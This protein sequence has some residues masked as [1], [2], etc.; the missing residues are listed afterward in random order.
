MNLSPP[1]LPPLAL[2]IF[3]GLT[4]LWS[5]GF[6]HLVLPDGESTGP[7]AWAGGAAVLAASM[8]TST[9][10]PQ[11]QGEETASKGGKEK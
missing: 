7:L 11:S 10:P 5:A 6:A 8:L 4:P 3:H 1:F 9:S 2:Q